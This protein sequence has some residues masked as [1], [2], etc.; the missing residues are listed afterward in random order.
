M[1]E[2]SD[3]ATPQSAQDESDSSTSVDISA[4]T[5]RVS[6]LEDTVATIGE[7][8]K[9]LIASNA[10][11]NETMNAFMTEMK[12]VIDGWTATEEAY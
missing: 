11:T 12:D 10:A 3:S 6:S 4:M 2:P 7:G 1:D 5:T 9:N 8:I